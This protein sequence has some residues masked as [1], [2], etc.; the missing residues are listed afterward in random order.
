[1]KEILSNLFKNNDFDRIIEFCSDGINT[2]KNN[3]ILYGARGK[4][5]LEKEKY[6]EA[7]TD[8]SSA[9]QL[10]NN[11]A[12]G[13]YNRA[14]CYYFLNNSGLSIIDFK[15]AKQLDPDIYAI[16]FYLGAN[17]ASLNENR[18]ALEYFDEH[19]LAYEDI[20]ALYY[21]AELFNIM[22]LYN[23]ANNDIVGILLSEVSDI[24]KYEKMHQL[25]KSQV[26]PK[27][28]LHKSTDIQ[29][30]GFNILTKEENRSGVYILEF[31][32]NEYYIGQT[33]NIK[34]RIKQHYKKYEDILNTYF[35]FIEQELLLDKENEVISLFEMNRFRI[36]NLKQINFLNLFNMDNQ[37]QWKKNYEYNKVDGIKFDNSNLRQEFSERYKL[38]KNKKYFKSLIKML[39]IYIYKTIPNFIASEFNYW[40]ITCM[41][42]YLKKDNCISRININ[43][44]PILSI[45]E[46]SEDSIYFMLFIS[47]INILKYLKI[48]KNLHT[49]LEEFPSLRLQLREAFFEK[50][51]NDEVTLIIDQNEFIELLNNPIIISSIRIFN[52]R[53]MNNVGKEIDYRR[54]ISHCLDLS[55]FVIR[56]IT[57][58]N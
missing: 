6:I 23:K 50:T 8:I 22:G 35:I 48:K 19:L 25:T 18:K 32:N 10:N 38:L 27:S 15:K 52:L 47:K 31:S 41:P 9:L 30:L 3:Y 42:K 20:T 44:V 14:L 12:N 43:S 51:N 55:D 34:T 45:F 2:D 33:K 17:Y 46:K 39:S 26:N 40:N 53:M 11:Y 4:A 54:K 58:K 37:L 56:N 29:K 49:I 57:G 13:Y 28:L 16:N 21:R 7:I 5:Y 36:R 1:M 24:F